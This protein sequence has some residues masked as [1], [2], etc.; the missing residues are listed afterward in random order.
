MGSEMIKDRLT[1]TPHRMYSMLCTIVAMEG[2]PR[3]QI[4]ALAQ[5]TFIVDNTGT[6]SLV[7][8]YLAR[9]GLIEEDGSPQRKVR[10]SESG[11]ESINWSPFR[12]QMQRHLLGNTEE[13]SDNFLLGQFTAWYAVQDDTVMTYS[14]S[15]LEMRFHEDLY[16]NSSERVLS[17]EPGISAWRTWAEFLGFGWPMKFN[18]RDE[19]RIV[20]DA[21][22]RIAPLL[23]TL[24]LEENVETSFGALM[25]ELSELCPELDGGILYERCWQASR[26][27][28]VRGNRLSLMLSTAL[29]TLHKSGEIKLI[30]RPDAAET[31]TLFPAQSQIDRVSHIRRKAV[32]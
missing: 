3:N 6:A 22:V 24:L 7:Y 16:P 4:I 14:K 12:T 31:W 1:V 18:Q 5:P 11:R 8:R 20:P 32:A 29:R 9:F 2:Q 10:A 13:S 15:E 28:E 21:T 17:E 26:G 19:M 30:N 27:S 25:S 23:S